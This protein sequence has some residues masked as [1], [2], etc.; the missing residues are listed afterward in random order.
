MINNI[1]TRYIVLLLL[2]VIGVSCRTN[3]SQTKNKTPKFSRVKSQHVKHTNKRGTVETNTKRIYNKE[4]KLTRANTY[5]LQDSLIYYKLYYYN[6]NGQIQDIITYSRNCVNKKLYVVE[7]MIL[8]EYNEKQQQ[9]E[10]IVTGIDNSQN[11]NIRYYYND[12]GQLS[13]AKIYH[14]NILGRIVSFNYNKDGLLTTKLTHCVAS[15]HRY[16][17]EYSYITGTLTNETTYN[18]RGKIISCKNL[19]YNTINEKILEEEHFYCT[20]RKGTI[21]RHFNYE[22]TR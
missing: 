16:R 15:N 18:K 3:Y 10:K 13:K 9:I 11:K 7:K 19:Y 12:L 2:A 5:D 21:T 1:A 6:V 14:K 17:T 20:K 22:V 4:G 8:F